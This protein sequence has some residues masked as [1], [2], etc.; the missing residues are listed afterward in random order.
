MDLF[1]DSEIF[2]E[3]NEDL[4]KY[5]EQ[6][7]ELKEISEHSNSD[8]LILAQT[9]QK[10]IQAMLNLTKDYFILNDFHF[11]NHYLTQELRRA[12]MFNRK[13]GE[14]IKREKKNDNPNSLT[15]I[16]LKERKKRAKNIINQSFVKSSTNIEDNPFN[17]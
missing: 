11:D 13:I 15:N 8:Q 6:L 7:N 1:G 16:S 4:K 9:K 12:S 14:A 2:K 10:S 3:V 5:S 17:K